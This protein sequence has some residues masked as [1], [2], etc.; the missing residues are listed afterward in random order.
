MQQPDLWLFTFELDEKTKFC[1][2][3][4]FSVPT[5]ND[6]PNQAALA[7]AMVAMYLDAQLNA[8]K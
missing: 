8:K 7:A 4:M 6:R 2:I 5:S 3:F 1:L